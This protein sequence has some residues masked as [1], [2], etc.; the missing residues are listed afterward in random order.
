MSELDCKCLAKRPVVGRFAPSPT[1]RMHAGNI[2][3]ALMAWVVAKVQGGRI[4][5]RIDDIDRDRCKSVFADQVQ[6]DFEHLGL[7]W[8]SGPF[9]QSDNYDAY[10]D[11]FETLQAI[12]CVYPC[13][14]TR[15]DLMSASAPHQGE[16]RVYSGACRTRSNGE[17]PQRFPKKTPSY[18]L[19]VPRRKIA[20]KDVFQEKFQQDLASECG[21]FVIKRTDGAFAYHLATV[22]DDAAQ[23]IT[24]V[25]R[26]CDLLDSTPQQ[27]FLHDQLGSALPSYGHI[28]LFVAKDGRRLSKRHADAGLDAL[29]ARY[30]SARGVIGAIAFHAGLIPF[31]EPLLPEELLTYCELSKVQ[32]QLGGRTSILWE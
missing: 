24:S 19:Q 9:Y 13:F 11:A 5:L 16:R 1:G 22:V 27:I 14:C 2:F 31:E 6:T 26:G 32:R 17:T 30:K 8:D 23:G 7:T 10:Q 28:P 29:L 21:D 25:V 18:R 15:A 20:F 4:V 3:A 12:S